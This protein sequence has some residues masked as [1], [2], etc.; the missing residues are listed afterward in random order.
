MGA[1]IAATGRYHLS[2]RSQCQVWGYSVAIEEQLE[3]EA[4]AEILE[5]RVGRTPPPAAGRTTASRNGY[6][7]SLG[8][9]Y[10]VTV[11]AYTIVGAISL[12]CQ[13]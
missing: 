4:E 2:S 11:Q 10:V 9:P 7:T 6:A 13:S 1:T 8:S 3:V 5:A 12:V